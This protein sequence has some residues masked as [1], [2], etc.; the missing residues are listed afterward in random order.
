MEPTV[1]CLSESFEWQRSA[2]ERYNGWQWAYDQRQTFACTGCEAV[3]SDATAAL[4]RERTDHR[5]RPVVA[6][7]RAA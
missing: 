3:L 1:T 6:L 5:L 2:A 4:H 7:G